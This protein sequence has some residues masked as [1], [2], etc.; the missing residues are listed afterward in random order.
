[1]TPYVLE[2][3]A[4]VGVRML[5]FAEDARQADEILA[6]RT[7]ELFDAIAARANLDIENEVILF[8]SGAR[9]A[10]GDECLGSDA[11]DPGLIV[12]DECDHD[13]HREGGDEGE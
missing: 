4:S 11:L 12:F 6:E 10:Y 1:M 3:M 7:E 8:H 13:E 9:A 2:A 5:I